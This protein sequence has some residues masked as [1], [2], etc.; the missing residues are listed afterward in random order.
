MSL[1]SVWTGQVI[2]R[3]FSKGFNARYGCHTTDT[4]VELARRALK[5]RSF[6]SIVKM[7]FKLKSSSS[8]SIR[9]CFLTLLTLRLRKFTGTRDCL[10]GTRPKGNSTWRL[11][12][13]EH[14]IEVR[15]RK[16]LKPDLPPEEKT[17]YKGPQG[18]KG[19][20]LQSNF[21]VD[22]IC[23]SIGYKGK[24]SPMTKN[25]WYEAIHPSEEV[26]SRS[27]S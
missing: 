14:V 27:P 12:K 13:K 3:L 7:V 24:C 18:V 16:I 19:E 15:N 2:P 4:K 17:S 8:L 10:R 9:H 23:M 11:L 22:K 26:L 1:T 21:L 20:L 25:L 6:W 5:W